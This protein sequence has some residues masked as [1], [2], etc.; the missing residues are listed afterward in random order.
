M[1]I[2]ASLFAPW[3]G[4]LFALAG[5]LAVAGIGATAVS[6]VHIGRQDATIKNLTAANN[7]WAKNWER[8]TQIR[9]LEHENTMLLQAKLDL[10][11][12]DS[13]ANTARLRSL[14]ANNA[15]VK[16][17]LGTRLPA[18]LRGLLNEGR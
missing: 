3:K 6:A 12:A 17:L 7:K 18:D 10:L 15:E 13:T 5:V 2:L 1:T 14:E 16:Q 8:V 9:A 11:A 4:H